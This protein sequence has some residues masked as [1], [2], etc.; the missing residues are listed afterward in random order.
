MVPIGR[1]AVRGRRHIDVEHF[2]SPRPQSS[3]G[4]SGKRGKV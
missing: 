4:G 1:G 2:R 3:L